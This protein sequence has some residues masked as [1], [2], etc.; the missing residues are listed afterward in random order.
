MKDNLRD[1]PLFTG[2]NR[3]LTGEFDFSRPL[4]LDE[5]NMVVTLKRELAETLA[6]YAAENGVSPSEVISEVLKQ[7]ER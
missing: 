2:S 6:S 1:L 5:I 7:I 4:A 3:K